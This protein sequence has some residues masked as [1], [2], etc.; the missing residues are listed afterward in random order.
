MLGSVY[1]LSARAPVEG[2][3]SRYGDNE[4]G[5]A[6][7]APAQPEEYQCGD[8]AKYIDGDHGVVGFREV[9]IGVRHHLCRRAATL[10]RIAIGLRAAIPGPDGTAGSGRD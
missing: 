7:S 3:L 6:W 9:V 2:A 1:L 5:C 10:R 4:T 8:P